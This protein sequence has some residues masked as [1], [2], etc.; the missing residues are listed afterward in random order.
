MRASI[1]PVVAPMG[2]DDAI[3]LVRLHERRAREA[4]VRPPGPR[5]RPRPKVARRSGR[6]NGR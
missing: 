5:A 3:R 2:V 6:S 1:D 4:A